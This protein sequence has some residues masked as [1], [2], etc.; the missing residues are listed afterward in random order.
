M[1]H[2]LHDGR[3]LEEVLERHRV[4]LQRLDGHRHVVALPHRLVH[5]A[6]LPWANSN[7]RCV[8]LSSIVLSESTQINAY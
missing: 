3:F 8:S 1:F 4:L 2:L 5:V 6:V 7:E